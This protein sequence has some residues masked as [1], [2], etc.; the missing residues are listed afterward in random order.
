MSFK[1]V[2]LVAA[3]AFALFAGTSSALEVTTQQLTL[4]CVM[5]EARMLRIPPPN[6]SC[7]PNET[8]VRFNDSSST[9]E[10]KAQVDA[11]Q[12]ALAAETAARQA[13]DTA[14][15]KDL[16]SETAERL[17]ADLGVVSLR[18]VDSGGE[19][20]LAAGSFVNTV[21]S[22]TFEKV[23]KNSSIKIHW[24]G[25]IRTNDNSTSGVDVVIEVDGVS[26]QHLFFTFGNAPNGT[27]SAIADVYV[28]KLAPGSHAVSVTLNAGGH[29]TTL[30][31]DSAGRK[32]WLL[33]V[34]ENGK[35]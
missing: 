32:P 10:L 35:R 29:P 3:A 31:P 6:S 28:E 19:K 14:L 25:N 11:L 27:I 24:D 22:G 12:S 15:Q 34:F 21:A 7:K 8:T 18:L 9:A 30:S 4:G 20:A 13:L 1:S 23:S 2:S 33:E 5:P 17:K 26:Q 16:A